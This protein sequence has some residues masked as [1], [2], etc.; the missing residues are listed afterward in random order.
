MGVPQQL[1]PAAFAKDP[2]SVPSTHKVDAD[3]H[4]NSSFRPSG[5]LFWPPW[6]LHA[7]G[8]HTC[9][10]ANTQMHKKIK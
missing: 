5:S 4:G 7:C 9:I 2:G 10:Q 8:A 3:L 1:E 6:A